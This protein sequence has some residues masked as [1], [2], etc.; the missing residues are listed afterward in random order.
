MCC[1]CRD[2][3]HSNYDDDVHLSLV[4]D[5][6]TNALTRRGYLCERHREMYA[7]DGYDVRLL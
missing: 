1:D 3:E 5:P 2:G 7:E 4:R 6:E